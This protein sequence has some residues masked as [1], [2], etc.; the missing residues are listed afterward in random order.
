MQDQHL[1]RNYIEL[2]MLNG[3]CQQVVKD[4]H[5]EEKKHFL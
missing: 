1:S 5:H 3:V 2:F 4:V